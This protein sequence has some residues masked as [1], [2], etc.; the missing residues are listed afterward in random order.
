MVDQ[1]QIS[2]FF[3]DDNC[4]ILFYTMNNPSL[5][6]YTIIKLTFITIKSLGPDDHNQIGLK[7]SLIQRLTVTVAAGTAWQ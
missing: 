7:W 1:R 6:F 2:Q 3:P 5:K 4:E